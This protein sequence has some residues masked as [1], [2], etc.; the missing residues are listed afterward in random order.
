MFRSS[1][2]E[3]DFPAFR[4]MTTYS[5]TQDTKWWLCAS[6]VGNMGISP[7]SVCV[8]QKYP[9]EEPPY[10][11]DSVPTNYATVDNVDYWIEQISCLDIQT[12]C[13]FEYNLHRKWLRNHIWGALGKEMTGCAYFLH[14][15]LLFASITAERI[16][17]FIYPTDAQLDCSKNVK[18]YIKIYLRGAPTCFDFSQPSSGSYYMCFAKV[19]SINN[20]L[21]YVVYRISSV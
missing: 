6:F 9:W 19:V 10:T 17:F 7:T 3:D 8:L 15:V 13:T 5:L 20:Q 21:K 16:E 2:K 12:L 1:V 18:I 14:H 4:H 11:T